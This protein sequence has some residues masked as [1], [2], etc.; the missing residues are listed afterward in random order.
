MVNDKSFHKLNNYKASI[1]R[2]DRS[3][4]I[5]KQVEKSSKLIL[6]GKNQNFIFVQNLILYSLFLKKKEIQKEQNGFYS[7]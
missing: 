6:N 2:N 1:P 7:N 5:V 4:F 3:K